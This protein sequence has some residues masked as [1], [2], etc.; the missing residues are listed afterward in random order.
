[1]CSAFSNV[2]KS[3]A[4]QADRADIL[5]GGSSFAQVLRAADSCSIHADAVITPY[6]AHKHLLQVRR[7]L[8]PPEH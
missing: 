6:N 2:F 4:I 1:M 8:L 7:A 5:A 3:C